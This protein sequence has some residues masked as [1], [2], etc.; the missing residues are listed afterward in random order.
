M[1][2]DKWNIH[3]GSYNSSKYSSGASKDEKKIMEYHE[4]KYGSKE[5]NTSSDYMRREDAKDKEEKKQDVFDSLEEDKKEQQ[6]LK[7]D[8]IPFKAAKQIFDEKKH[9][10]KKNAGKKDTKTIED[11][12]KKAIDEEKKVIVM[13]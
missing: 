5:K 6:E 12:I 10:D 2:E 9:Y 7:E 1:D 13:D 4:Q 8:E 11:A 3:S